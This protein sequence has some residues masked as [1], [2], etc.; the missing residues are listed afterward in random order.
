MSISAPA[1]SMD[2]MLPPRTPCPMPA[3]LAPHHTSDVGAN[4][5]LN[6]DVLLDVLGRL[7]GRNRMSVAGTC[8]RLRDVAHWTFSCL[9]VMVPPSTEASAAAAPLQCQSAPQSGVCFSLLGMRMAQM[10]SARLLLPPRSAPL[11]APLASPRRRRAATD[12][13]NCGSTASQPPP[14]P[15]EALDRLIAGVLSYRISLPRLRSLSLLQHDP[16]D[17]SSCQVSYES[18]AL[19]AAACHNLRELRL[20]VLSPRAAA[21]LQLLPPSL[22]S[23]ELTVGTQFGFR[24]CHKQCPRGLDSQ[25]SSEIFPRPHLSTCTSLLYLTSVPRLMPPPF[26]YFPHN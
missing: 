16:S 2:S 17:L 3:P 5:D 6:V 23:L 14:A 20:P 21:A 19:I 11:N 12:E 1:G 9:T 15:T 8:R 25:C 26:P 10:S 13:G 4:E 18:L 24:S 22:T 7:S